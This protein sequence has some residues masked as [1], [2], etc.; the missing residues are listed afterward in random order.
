MK[1]K[2]LAGL[3]VGLAALAVTPPV[4]GQS[5]DTALTV[6]RT[7]QG[8]LA[9]GD[10]VS[11]GKQQFYDQWT[12]RGT[13]GQRLSILM[14]SEAFDTQLR[15]VLSDGTTLVNDD[16]HW[17]PETTNSRIDLTVPSTGRISVR[18]QAF[19][20]AETGAYT[21]RL[22]QTESLAAAADN[23]VP[24][25]P[26]TLG[27]SRNG[28][29]TSGEDLTIAGR[30]TDRYVFNGTR[31][32]RV[33]LRASGEFDTMLTVTGPDNFS[34]RNDDDTTA[35]EQ[36]L[37]SRVLATLPANGQYTISVTSYGRGTTGSYQLATGLN[38][39]GVPDTETL[40][41]DATPLSFGR[42]LTSVLGKEDETLGSGEYLERYSFEGRRGQPITIDLSS[43][44][45]D[46]YLILRA[47]S[48]EQQDIDDTGQ[49]L[50]SR[51]ERVLEEDG[52]Y[53]II[54]TSYAP[55]ATG[56][57][58]LALS[59]GTTRI[60]ANPEQRQVFAISVGIADYGGNTSNLSYT[61]TDAR[62][63]FQKFEELG[64]LR[65]ESIVLTNQDATLP[66]F[67]RA[68]QRVA[69]QAGPDDIFLFFYSGHGSQVDDPNDRAELDGRDETLVF[70]DGEEL[71]DDDLALMFADIRAGTTMIVLDACFSGGF[72]R[73]LITRPNM[74]GL[75]S[76]EEDLTSLV[77]S[78]FNAGGYLSRFFSDGVGGQADDN[79][80]GNITAGELVAYLRYRFREQCDGR[81]CIEA[82]TGDAQRNHQELVVQRGSVEVDDI[83]VTLPDQF[84]LMRGGD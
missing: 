23:A 33:D 1:S 67:R 80:D 73:D 14:E 83:L 19:R 70:A 32:Q 39:A 37:N 79:G 36:T 3:G 12:V 28:S 60:P 7:F 64:M 48:G 76:S 84:G 4:Q 43:D 27:Q 42:T 5:Q 66:A 16:N 31:G 35:R 38:R 25:A 78:E 68:F 24:P 52:V 13:P 57:F 53:T 72:E 9:A 40:T 58:Q 81:N 71:T 15:A 47:P 54:A 55:G 63:L 34:V 18:A 21:I 22:E 45:F 6:G 59:E 8:E 17:V 75:F 10:Q 65:E 44:D 2:F 46:T 56:N 26:I 49:S 50:N 29:L 77:A 20:P 11:G 82:E 30:Y 41:G 74:M 69:S 61:D 51:F 62:K